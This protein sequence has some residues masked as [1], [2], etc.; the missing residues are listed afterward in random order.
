MD[1]LQQTVG[2]MR[3]Y[4]LIL[5]LILA[6]VYGVIIGITVAVVTAPIAIPLSIILAIPVI[7]LASIASLT[8]QASYCAFQDFLC[9]Y[10]GEPPY[11]SWFIWPLC[12]FW[13]N[14]DEEVCDENQIPELNMLLLD[15]VPL[16]LDATR[17]AVE[18]GASRNWNAGT[19]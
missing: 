14:I 8:G 12:G 19:P 18:Q 13:T 11:W 1:I 3:Q 9:G 5:V 6:I 7:L 2:A 10:F 4:N 17:D 16:F 15:T